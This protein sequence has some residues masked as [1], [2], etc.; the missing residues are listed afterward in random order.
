MA[1]G[2][3]MRAIRA[4][5]VN[6]QNDLADLSGAPNHEEELN[7]RD[8]EDGSSGVPAEA[9]PDPQNED[10][11]KPEA[12]LEPEGLPSTATTTKASGNVPSTFPTMTPEEEALLQAFPWLGVESHSEDHSDEEGVDD[13]DDDFFTPVGRCRCEDLT[14]IA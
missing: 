9:T 7:A 13:D 11:V 10:G 2:N 12:E 14:N 4:L 3:G 8:G 6:P 1:C 5:R